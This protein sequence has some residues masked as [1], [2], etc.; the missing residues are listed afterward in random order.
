MRPPPRRPLRTRPRSMSC[1]AN[2]GRCC[3]G[4][5]AAVRGFGQVDPCST[6]MN[7]AARS[8][9]S[10]SSSNSDPGFSTPI[11]ASRRIRFRPIEPSRIEVPFTWPS[12]P[13]NAWVDTLHIRSQPSSCELEDPHDVRP[14]GPGIGGLTLSP[15]A[16]EVFRSGGCSSRPVAGP[17]RRS[18]NP[19]LP[20][21]SPPRGGPSRESWIPAKPAGRRPSGSEA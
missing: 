12:S 3:R 21:R 7:P 14:R 11:S 13:K 4:R 2:R 16:W 17:F 10:A 6:W 20:R 9:R 5:R 8:T 15:P 18:R 19:C 1:P